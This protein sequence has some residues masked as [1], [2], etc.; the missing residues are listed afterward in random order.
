M[1][2]TDRKSVLLNY[3]GR[4]GRERFFTLFLA[5]FGGLWLFLEPLS[6]FKVVDLPA[7][8]TAYCGLVIGGILI[9]GTIARPTKSLGR[10]LHPS[11]TEITVCVGDL[12]AQEG[13]I[14]VGVSDAFDTETDAGVISPQSVQGQLLAN[15][16]AQDRSALDSDMA[17]ALQGHPGSVDDD[18]SFGKKTRY[19]VGTTAV[20]QKPP[21]RLF[22][23]AYTRMKSTP[24]AVVEGSI[25][26]LRHSLDQLWDSVRAS[27]QNEPLHMPI[28]GS[29]LARLGLSRTLLIQIIVLSFVSVSARDQVS[30]SLTIWIRHGDRDHVDMA[31]LRPWLSAVCGK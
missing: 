22:L 4:V 26:E 12:L 18:K 23:L 8:I 14:V 7:G 10:K 25:G 15:I 19:P 3:F 6:V 21:R 29:H 28:V 20:I 31:A 9:A 5:S 16:Y 2:K 27:G 11:D 13:N 24:P 30:P 1:S 17:A